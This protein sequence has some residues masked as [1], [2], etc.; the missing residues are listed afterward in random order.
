MMYRSKARYHTSVPENFRTPNSGVG[1]NSTTGEVLSAP[2]RGVLPAVDARPRVRINFRDAIAA[3]ESTFKAPSP[4]TDTQDTD[5]LPDRPDIIKMPWYVTCFNMGVTQAACLLLLA[6]ITFMP[7]QTGATN[8][9]PSQSADSMASTVPNML[10]GW[11]IIG[12]ILG[13]VLIPI[14]RPEFRAKFTLNLGL[15]LLVLMILAVCQQQF[16]SVELIFLPTMGV[17]A[18]VWLHA[19]SKARTYFS[20]SPTLRGWQMLAAAA[21]V[22]L[23]SL[24]LFM[25]LT[26]GYFDNIFGAMDSDYIRPLFMLGCSLGIAAGAGALTVANF[27][28]ISAWFNRFSG[29]LALT[30]A[31]A[32]GGVCYLSASKLSNAFD[33]HASNIPWLG[34]GF[35]WLFL[36]I[37]ACVVLIWSGLT[38]RFSLSA[39]R[40]RQF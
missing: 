18:L 27:P 1:A 35:M 4:E 29:S 2:S 33:S 34:T 5:Q 17:L 15:S 36:L 19:V 7:K 38:Q 25:E 32:I 14:L 28:K 16:V 23:W 40:E 13:L 30:A 21:V 24:P 10:H 26:Q 37:A 12:A 6:G 31:V 3:D 9:W 20:E 39:L 8:W 22:L 11:E